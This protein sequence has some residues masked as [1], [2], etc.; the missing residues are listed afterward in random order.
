MTAPDCEPGYRVVAEGASA[1]RNEV[2]ARFG[3][4][5]GLGNRRE[6][7]IGGA[8][9]S[10]PIGQASLGRDGGESVAS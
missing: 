4:G 1:F 8:G 9:V 6:A 7:R 10:I 2:A 5:E 3:P